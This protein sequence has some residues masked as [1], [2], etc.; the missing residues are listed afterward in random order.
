MLDDQPLRELLGWDAAWYL[1]R[2][3]DVAKA[4]DNGVCA[5]PLYH[6]IW[7]GHSEG[8]FPSAAAEARAL[9]GKEPRT[10]IESAQ[11]NLGEYS[12]PLDWPVKGEPA[13]TFLVKLT[14]GFFEQYLA[15]PVILDIGYKGGNE[16]AVPIV[17]HAV[18]IDTDYPGYDGVRLPF[19]DGS[20]DT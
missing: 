12:V 1:H 4:L 16:E 5:D 19:D 14:N 11:I 2:Y 20:V 10:V 13:K 6:Y 17:P 15:G 7:F 3:R 8:R 18:G 9:R